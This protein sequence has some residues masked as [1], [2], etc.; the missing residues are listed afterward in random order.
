MADPKISMTPS[1]ES[2]AVESH[3]Y[4]TESRKMRVKFKGGGTYEYDDVPPE[5]YAAFTGANS[6]GA[7]HN[8]KIRN[9]HAGRKVT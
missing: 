1:P 2:D 4:D 3:G 8:K 6:M 7:F 9:N 5:K